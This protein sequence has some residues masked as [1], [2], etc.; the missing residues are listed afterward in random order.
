MIWS[1]I[2]TYSQGRL[3]W[4]KEQRT[5]RGLNRVNAFAGD[6]AGAVNKRGYYVVTVRGEKILRH[7]I[8]WEMHNGEIPHGMEVDHDNGI[9]GDDRIENLNLVTRS[10]NMKNLAKRKDNKSGVTGVRFRKD[11][12]KWVAEITSEKFKK[13]K[14]FDNFVSACEQRIIWEIELN[15]NS[16]HGRSK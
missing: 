8:V 15:F 4:K 10:G 3:Y 6:S 1:D 9:P 16:N 5:G 13:S 12:S 11:R 2:F 7:R 14:M